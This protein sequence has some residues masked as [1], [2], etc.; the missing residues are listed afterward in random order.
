MSMH[1]QVEAQ[2]EGFY[3]EG[4]AKGLCWDHAEKY[5]WARHEGCEGLADAMPAMTHVEFAVLSDMGMI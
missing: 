5:A 3:E 2:L 1:P 4:L